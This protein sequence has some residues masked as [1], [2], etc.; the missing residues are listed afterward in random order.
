MGWVSLLPS[1]MPWAQFVAEIAEGITRDWIHRPW[2]QFR[3]EERGGI[4]L[5][6]IP[7]VQ[8]SD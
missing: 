5:Q 6:V 7:A 8:S 3:F 4:Q 2:Q 1:W